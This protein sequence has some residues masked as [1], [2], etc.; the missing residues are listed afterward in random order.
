MARNEDGTFAK[1]NAGGPGRPSRRVEASYLVAMTETVTPDQWQQIVDK[2]VQQAVAGDD[3]ARG[4]L[5]KYL[6][7][8][9]QTLKPRP[10]LRR[11]HIEAATIDRQIEKDLEFEE[12]TKHMTSVEK[13]MYGLNK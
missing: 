5:S 11:S 9:R 2:A 4:W 10:T 6:L 7:G 3:K 1:G 13:A 8:E 12:K